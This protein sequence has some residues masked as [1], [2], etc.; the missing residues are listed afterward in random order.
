MLAEKHSGVQVIVNDE[1]LYMIPAMN[2]G[3]RM[4]QGEY[5]MLLDDDNVIDPGMITALIRVLECD[6][7][8][9]IVG[10]KMYYQDQPGILWYA[11]VTVSRV[12]SWTRY[13]GLGEKDVGQ[14][15][16][17]GET[18]HVPNCSVMRRAAH[19]AAGA[20]DDVY[21]GTYAEAD[22]AM[23]IRRKGFEVVYCPTAITYHDVPPRG[24]GSPFRTPARAY[25]L[26]RNRVIYM[27]RY[28][29]LFSFLAFMLVFYPLFNLY[30]LAKGLQVR[31]S[32]GT[33]AY[34]RGIRDGI[35]YALFQSLRDIPTS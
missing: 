29:G 5:L 27:K 21:R 19:E 35:S 34:A 17:P 14:Y 15:E 25:L 3:L 2:M 6:P 10:P 7:N 23:R 13:R 12:T 26:A 9:G 22:Y 31:D 16:K 8:V 18:D 1:N 11:G 28:A 32:A 4:A 33:K 24:K 30:Y 20:L